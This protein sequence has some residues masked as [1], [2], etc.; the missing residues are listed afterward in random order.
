M[1]DLSINIKRFDCVYNVLPL[2]THK[3][4]I[5]CKLL[6]KTNLFLAEKVVSL[7]VHCLQNYNVKHIVFTGKTR[8]TRATRTN[9]VTRRKGTHISLCK[10]HHQCSTT[11]SLE[12]YP[13]LNCE[14]ILSTCKIWKEQYDFQMFY[15]CEF[16]YMYRE[17][18]FCKS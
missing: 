9:W 2:S 10:S 17:N 1:W 6:I 3:K 11:V 12:T 8:Q 14:A 4:N 16:L 5:H 18:E 7:T 15:Q 13:L